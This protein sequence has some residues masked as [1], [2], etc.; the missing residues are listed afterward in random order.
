MRNAAI[1]AL[2]FVALATPLHAQSGDQAPPYAK[3]L[4]LSGPRFG[5]TLLSDGVVRKL[6]EEENVQLSSAI[7]QFGW[8]FEKQFY[9]KDSGLTGL[10][11]WVFLL[12]GLDQGVSIPSLSWLVG[13]R[14]KE[15]AEFGFGPNF[16]PGGAA[17]AVA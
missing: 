6:S 10:N 12:G 17:L 5:L 1:A 11:E 7:S 15:G 8:Q 2:L 4:R 14:T 9:A 13:L 3:T 16:T